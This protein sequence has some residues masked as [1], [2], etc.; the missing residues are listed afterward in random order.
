M[1]KYDLGFVRRV[2]MLQKAGISS[3]AS[4]GSG[5]NTASKLK[6][7]E[8]RVQMIFGFINKLKTEAGKMVFF[9]MYDIE[10]DKVRNQVSKYLIQEG[11]L[12]VQK[13]IFMAEMERRDFDKI[14]QTL[15]EVNE[16]YNNE[17]SIMVVPVS[18]EQLNSMQVIGK[19]LD[20]DFILQNKNTMIF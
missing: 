17:D 5:K 9:I 13:S 12:R 1:T 20:V 8:D 4:W 10:N 15:R 11:C 16:V 7:L 6:S 18:P 19:N 2:Q 3:A 14:A